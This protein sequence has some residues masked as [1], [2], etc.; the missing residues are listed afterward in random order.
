MKII[1][2]YDTIEGIEINKNKIDISDKDIIDYV[3]KYYYPDDVFDIS[4]IE[5]W[6]IKNMTNHEG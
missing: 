4:D 2:D 5:E 6:N 3:R 1:L